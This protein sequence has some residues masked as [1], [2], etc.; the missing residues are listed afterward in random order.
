MGRKHSVSRKRH[1]KKKPSQVS[2]YTR[3]TCNSLKKESCSSE[4]N[5]NWTRSKKT[6]CRAKK[7]VRK[8][9]DVYEGPLPPQFK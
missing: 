1:S 3:G 9:K 8:H 2:N 7:G 6:P 5:C 4:P